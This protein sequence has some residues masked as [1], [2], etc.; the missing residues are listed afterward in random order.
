MLSH[1]LCTSNLL[2]QQG[3]YCDTTLHQDNTSAIVLEIK[4]MVNSSKIT[5]H[6]RIQ[7]YFIKNY[8]IRKELNVK[9]CSTYDMLEVFPSKPL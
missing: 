9:R 2:K 7:F 1:L 8:I 4:G 3:Y 6:I 5:Q